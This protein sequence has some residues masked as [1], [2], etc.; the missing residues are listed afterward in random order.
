L[1]DRIEEVP[2]AP[3]G[4]AN[5]LFWCRDPEVLLEGPA[6]T[7]KTRALL[8]YVYWCCRT[9]PGIRVL[10]VRK[11]RASLTESV[12][13][14][15]EQK[16]LPNND[17]ITGTA[18]AENR[19]SYT[20]PRDSNEVYGETY[21]GKS[22]IVLGGMDKWTR[23]MSTEY[24]LICYFES[25]EGEEA[26]WEALLTR[27]RNWRMPWQQCIADTNP[28]ADQHWLN[29]RASKPYT[30]PDALRLVLPKARPN[31]T[32]MTRLLSRH[33]DNPMLWD[34]A[35]EK[36]WPRGAGYMQKLY[37]LTGPR[38]GRLLRGEWV[39]SEGQVWEE[40][41][42][43]KHMA[44]RRRLDDNGRAMQD[45]HTRKPNGELDL[46]WYFVSIDWGYRAAG[47][48]QVWGVQGQFERM[49]RVH[50]IY[51]KGM[52]LDWWSE[53]IVQFDK[54]YQIQAA[55]CDPSRPDMMATLNQRLCE[56]RG[57]KMAHIAVPA[58]NDREA[59]WDMVRNGF[60]PGAAL[61]RHARPDEPIPVTR[62]KLFLCWEALEGRDKAL[63]ED[64]LPTCTEEEIPG[65]VW[66]TSK[67]GQPI[68]EESD[69]MCAD[70]GCDA[71]RY[72]AMFAWGQ[73]LT[74][75]DAKPKF[76]PDSMGGVLSHDDVTF[77]DD[78]A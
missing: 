8:E 2:Y 27:N 37:A 70:H 49:Y 4:A 50:E 1:V 63:I 17:C 65:Y 21:E 34:A 73:D 15:W 31:Q 77:D 29:R 66:K 19:R 75:E 72:A 7:G 13:V 55:V 3:W 44:W 74:P 62:P 5:D 10:F 56:F 33:K 43:E 48:M 51:R 14:T 46:D 28:D 78:A 76:A 32:Q 36:W 35:G 47:V 52:Q 26:E 39:G 24:D 45:G 20:F 61:S 30:V 54:R 68:K 16:V 59:G 53:A 25:A 40:F 71:M 12:L 60:H 9:F 22:H 18:S 64:K 38:A 23:I 57:R 42:R 11:T 67:D 41:D 6:G 69:P 58:N